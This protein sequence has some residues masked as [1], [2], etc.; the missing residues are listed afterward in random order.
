MELK[1]A[2]N[3]IW[4]MFSVVLNGNPIIIFFLRKQLMYFNK[5]FSFVFIHTILDS[6]CWGRGGGGG[7]E[8]WNQFFTQTMSLFYNI[9][10]N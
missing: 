3:P 10:D 5:W 1:I 7:A 9:Q 6:K 4:V 2:T 8:D